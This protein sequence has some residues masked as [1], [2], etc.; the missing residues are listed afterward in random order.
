MPGCRAEGSGE[1][2]QAV[3]KSDFAFKRSSWEFPLW[4]NGM[5]GLC[6][7]RMQVQSLTRHSGVKD[8]ALPQNLFLPCPILSIRKA[9]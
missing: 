9:H 2:V 5:V 8:P 3:D 4:H 6:R 1:A 7:A